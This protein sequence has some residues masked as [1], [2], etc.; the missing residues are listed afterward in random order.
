MVTHA[1]QF[2]LVLCF[3]YN[4]FESELRKSSFVSGIFFTDHNF[5]I[6]LAFSPCNAIGL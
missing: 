3:A 4:C 1:G 6:V 5:C 2:C